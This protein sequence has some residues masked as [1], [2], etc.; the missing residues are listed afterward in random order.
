MPRCSFPIHV[1]S[2]CTCS[3]N[4][5]F[6][7][8]KQATLLPETATS[9]PETGDFVAVFGNKIACFRIQCLLF[10]EPVWTGLYGL[11]ATCLCCRLVADWLLGS[12]CVALSVRAQAR[13]PRNIAVIPIATV[14]SHGRTKSCHVTVR[15][16]VDDS[17]SVI[18]RNESLQK[19]WR[20]VHAVWLIGESE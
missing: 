4:R 12:R 16:R 7:I 3:R 20:D 18:N 14:S 5:R 11:V 1:L 2:T 9:Y 6:C 8:Q 17:I 19:R 13:R 10:R 15:L